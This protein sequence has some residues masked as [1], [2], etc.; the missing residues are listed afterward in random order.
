METAVVV[1]DNT[2]PTIMTSEQYHR[3]A[4]D[5]NKEI[6]RRLN[7]VSK[8]LEQIEVKLNMIL[9]IM[10]DPSFD[11]EAVRRRNQARI[12]GGQCTYLK[13]EGV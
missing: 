7:E 12:E 2:I 8:R 11:L 1:N 10:Q 5:R 6:D 3:T 9:A 13:L 4:S